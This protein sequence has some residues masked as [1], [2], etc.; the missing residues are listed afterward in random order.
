MKKVVRFAV[1]K[2]LVVKQGRLLA[3]DKVV[4]ITWF[5]LRAN[6]VKIDL[7]LKSEIYFFNLPSTILF[8]CF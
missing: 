3:L 6:S 7:D 2:C 1:L 5:S 4:Y 8:K